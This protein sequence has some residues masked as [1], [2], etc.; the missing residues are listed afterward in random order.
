MTV[1]LQKAWEWMVV[2]MSIEV[3]VATENWY[4]K[5]PWDCVNGTWVPRVKEEPKR[6]EA[7]DETRGNRRDDRKQLL[8]GLI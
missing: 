7:T 5:K 8:K 2:P 6:N 4:L 1:A 3:D